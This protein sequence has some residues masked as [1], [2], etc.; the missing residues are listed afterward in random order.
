MLLQTKDEYERRLAAGDS[1]EEIFSSLRH[2]VAQRLASGTQLDPKPPLEDSQ[3]VS[4][5]TEVQ[6]MNDSEAVNTG[7]TLDEVGPF[8]SVRFKL[9]E[10]SP[11]TSHYLLA[12]AR[13]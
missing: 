7:D 3:P 5:E 4:S 12:T 2:I 1:E 9:A 13:R 11:V 10:T 6:P 8:T